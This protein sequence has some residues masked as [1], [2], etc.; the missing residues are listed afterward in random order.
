MVQE[1]RPQLVDLI[2]GLFM[3]AEHQCIA[4]AGQWPERAI[5]VAL[6]YPWI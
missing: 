3:D 1:L 6:L 2:H 5:H 4:M